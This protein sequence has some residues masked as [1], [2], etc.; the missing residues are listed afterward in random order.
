[1]THTVHSSNTW[2]SA[3]R[4]GGIDA[5]K[6]GASQLVFSRGLCMTS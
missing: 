1:M 3:P 2:N 6:Y 4:Q 5:I